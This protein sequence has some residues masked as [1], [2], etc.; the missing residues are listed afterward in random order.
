[1]E[2]DREEM[3]EDGDLLKNMKSHEIFNKKPELKIV[4]ITSGPLKGRQY[5][6]LPNGRLGRRVNKEPK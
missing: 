4:T 2:E 5:E 3:M 1:M 6:M